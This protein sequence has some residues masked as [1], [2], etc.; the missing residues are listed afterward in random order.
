SSGAT[1]AAGS[2]SSAS[3]ASASPSSASASPSSASASP[4][5]AS[6]SPASA[7]GGGSSP[8]GAGAPSVTTSSATA[9]LGRSCPPPRFTL[10]ERRR[11][12]SSTS[13]IFTLS[14]SPGRTTS[15]GLS[16]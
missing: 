10:S 12:D 8:S 11:R 2:A 14:L 3:S 1:S 15:A 6:A 16:T 7:S 4:S 5:S 9:P 13:R